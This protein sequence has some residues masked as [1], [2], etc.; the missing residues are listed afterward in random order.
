MSSPKDE[1]LVLSLL[2]MRFDPNPMKPSRT[3]IAL[4]SGSQ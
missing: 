4:V 3:C 2:K 1:S